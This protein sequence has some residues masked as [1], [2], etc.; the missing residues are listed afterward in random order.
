MAAGIDAGKITPNTTYN[1]KGTVTVSGAKITNYDLTT[2][3]PYGPGT[4][5]THVIEHSI[6]TG[7]MFAENQTGNDIFTSYLKNSALTRK[8]ESICRARS[9]AT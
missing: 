5:M 3:G 8:R 1:D 4:T 2:H 9:R 6:N 7:A